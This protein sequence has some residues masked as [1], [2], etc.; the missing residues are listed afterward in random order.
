M[1]RLLT[2]FQSASGPVFSRRGYLLFCDGDKILKLENG[3][4][5][6][7]REPSHGARSLTFDHQGCL[8][9]CEKE[10][11][12]RTEKS[13]KITVLARQAEPRDVIFAIDGNVYFACA[14]GVVKIKPTG[15]EVA[16]KIPQN[17][18]GLALSANQQILYVAGEKSIFRFDLDPDGRLG[19]PAKFADIAAAALK[20]DEAGAVYAATEQGVAIVGGT[21]IPVPE[22]VTGL[23]WG[24]GFHNLYITTKTSLYR[25]EVKASGTR[26]Y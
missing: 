17:A 20:T 21:T 6:T 16:W 26:T 19:S 12:T 13:G 7:F 8:L 14:S 11:V 25:A 3:K 15:G 1:E 9:A 4:L 24:E 23:N 18:T 5:S 2:G 22:P 10:R